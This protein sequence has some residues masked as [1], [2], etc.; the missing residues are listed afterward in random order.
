MPHTV[1]RCGF[2]AVSAGVNYADLRMSRT[3]DRHDNARVALIRIG[4][5]P[6][7]R[8]TETF[9]LPLP[10]GGL[11]SIVVLPD[12]DTCV[13]SAENDG[14]LYLVSLAE[15]RA[16]DRLVG[17]VGPLNSLALGDAGRLLLSAS[18]D[19]FVRV[20]DT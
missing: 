6:A 17:H 7:P 12:G 16:F 1:S 13:V 8:L 14:T 15:G 3:D 11:H 19:E 20:W 2:R 4:T 9:T 5:A 10:D 18:D